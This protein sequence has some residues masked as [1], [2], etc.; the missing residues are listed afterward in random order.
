MLATVAT[1]TLRHASPS[2]QAP[3]AAAAPFDST[4]AQNAVVNHY[5]D[6]LKLRLTPDQKPELIEHLKSL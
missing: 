6:H 4:I 1:A 5:D 3:S 2:A